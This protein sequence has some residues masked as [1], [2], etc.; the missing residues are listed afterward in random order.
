ME[1][2]CQNTQIVKKL[3]KPPKCLNVHY[4]EKQMKRNISGEAKIRRISKIR[5]QN[6]A[7]NSLLQRN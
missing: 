5:P 1:L 3:F 4:K 7:W 6:I 2:L